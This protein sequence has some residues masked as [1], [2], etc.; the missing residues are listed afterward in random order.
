MNFYAPST[1]WAHSEHWRK[2]PENDARSVPMLLT[3]K[4]EGEETN[5]EELRKK[6][7]EEKLEKYE[8]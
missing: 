8:R 1:E 7:L 6:K 2:V 3:E 4:N 5:K